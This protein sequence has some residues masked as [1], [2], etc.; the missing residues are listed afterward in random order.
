MTV[1]RNDQVQQ[2]GG[3]TAAYPEWKV[4]RAIGAKAVYQTQADEFGC[5]IIDQ[6]SWPMNCVIIEAD[7]TF[8]Y[9]EKFKTVS[10][11]SLEIM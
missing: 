11:A 5:K 3:N 7:E 2:G 10:L 9:G 8:Y 4:R 1:S 6:V